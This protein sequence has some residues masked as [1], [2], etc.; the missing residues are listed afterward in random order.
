VCLLL[1]RE[2]NDCVFASE[3]TSRFD[4]EG[5]SL[6]THSL[7]VMMT[8]S[9]LMEPQ[10]PTLVYVLHNVLLVQQLIARSG[11]VIPSIN[12]TP[13]TSIH[14]KSLDREYE[15][16]FCIVSVSFTENFSSRRIFRFRLHLQAGNIDAFR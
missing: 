14:R 11:V 9:T 3:C 1:F 7:D 10:S 13:P 8:T 4:S 15:R 2:V 5:D 12:H 16:K 6:L